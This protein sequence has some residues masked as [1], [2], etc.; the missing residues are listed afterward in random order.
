MAKK[1][2]AIAKTNEFVSKDL[3]CIIGFRATFKLV[4]GSKRVQ[5]GTPVCVLY[6]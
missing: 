3:I 4:C 2:T 5:E 1:V 6:Q